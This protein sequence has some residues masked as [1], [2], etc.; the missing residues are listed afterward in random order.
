MKS[1]YPHMRDYNYHPDPKTFALIDGWWD[2]GIELV[3][4]SEIK[5]HSNKNMGG[6]TILNLRKWKSLVDAQRATKVPVIFIAQYEDAL[7][8]QTVT[9]LT[10]IVDILKPEIVT[11]TQSVQRA[12]STEE[13]WRIPTGLMNV[14]DNAP[15]PTEYVTILLGL[16]E[17][18]RGN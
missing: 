1:A 12:T 6:T 17:Q 11:D 5:S 3:G 9:A 10:T 8:W 14:I 2:N 15:M 4:Y 18:I 13:V 16:S 7:A